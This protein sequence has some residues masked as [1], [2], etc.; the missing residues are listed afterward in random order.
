MAIEVEWLCA[1]VPPLIDYVLHVQDDVSS[2]PGLVDFS[3]P[4]GE[5]ALD[6]VYRV[7]T[8]KPQILSHFWSFMKLHESKESPEWRL[9]LF[10]ITMNQSGL[11]FSWSW[12]IRFTDFLVKLTELQGL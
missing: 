7:W 11:L 8:R 5:D 6:M 1:A 12:K 10:Q 9:F 4:G 2:I 3:F